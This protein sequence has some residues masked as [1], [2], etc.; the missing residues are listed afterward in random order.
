MNDFVSDFHILTETSELPRLQ[1]GINTRLNEID[2]AGHFDGPLGIFD[3][4][5][6]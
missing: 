5:K 4:I 2:A 3:N 6:V 1:V